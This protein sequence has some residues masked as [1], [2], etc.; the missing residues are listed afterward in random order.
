MD[1]IRGGAAV[2]VAGLVALLIMLPQA[3]LGD[4]SPSRP[5]DSSSSPPP[6]TDTPAVTTTDAPE[7]LARIAG[8]FVDFAEGA[9]PL[10]PSGGPVELYV[11]GH[12]QRRLAFGDLR[13][14]SRWQLCP[15]GG[16]ADRACPFSALDAVDDLGRRPAFTEEPP[17]APCVEK[18]DLPAD[19]A[20]LR[21]VTITRR[22]GGDCSSYAA[23]R[24]Y[25]D[26]DDHV[27]AVDLVLAG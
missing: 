22:G 16:Y 8:L 1:L 20:G 4:G 10:P 11:G 14:R 2:V 23:V 9:R 27:R 15:P 26:E 18:Q 3:L 21:G 6:G 24:L 7:D 12:H 25:V 13:L 5:D 17:G 19:L